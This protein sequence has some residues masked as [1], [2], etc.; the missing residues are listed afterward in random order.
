MTRVRQARRAARR[1]CE[2]IGVAVILGSAR[3]DV[4]EADQ[5]TTRPAF[6]GEWVEYDERGRGA[7][8][9]RVA[10]PPG[11]E[12]GGSFRRDRAKR[13]R[14]QTQGVK[15]LGRPERD[16]HVGD[17]C[18][19]PDAKPGRQLV[20]EVA[21][22]RVERPGEALDV[23]EPRPVLD[24]EEGGGRGVEGDEIGP[25]GELVV[26]VW[27]VEPDADRGRPKRSASISPIA[28]WTGSMAAT[29]PAAAGH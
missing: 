27:L 4:V 2:R 22:L 15:D 16:D 3:R 1:D 11:G 14:A 7:V 24:V 19:S 9:R 25:P 20:G 28:A 26:L 23:R 18:K 12:R 5:S 8:R 21:A 6:P 29:V 13:G 17:A 10:V